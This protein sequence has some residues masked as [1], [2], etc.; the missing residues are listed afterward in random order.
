MPQQQID[1]TQITEDL[2]DISSGS[3]R[4]SSLDVSNVSL[5]ATKDTATINQ[6]KHH[7]CSS[8]HNLAV[9]SSWTSDFQQGCMIVRTHEESINEKEYDISK[10]IYRINLQK[11]LESQIPAVD[12][13]DKSGGVGTSSRK[14]LSVS[15]HCSEFKMYP[16]TLGENPAGLE[17]P[18]ISIEW[19]PSASHV[20]NVDDYEEA[21]K[22]KNN[23]CRS[24]QEMRM[25]ADYRISILR[26]AGFSMT[27][28]IANK[29]LMGKLRIERA[30]TRRLLYQSSS[31][32]KVEKI[33]RGLKNLLHSG[34]KREER[35]F[36]AMSKEI[37]DAQQREIDEVARERRSRKLFSLQ[38]DSR[39]E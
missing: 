15:F 22:E 8:L 31:H 14:S 38:D 33:R 27:A 5:G 24:L 12:P 25:P 37:H 23:T 13:V 19:E 3:Y 11:R 26:K 7:S 30:E 2:I 21:K 4:P 39:E 20:W 9:D 16:M 36:L 17:G 35:K 18:P 28:I 6:S 34:K 1:F 10:K 29:R 32:E